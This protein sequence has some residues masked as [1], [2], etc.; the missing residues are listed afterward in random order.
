MVW[1]KG[2][3]A[4]TDERL[5]TV[6]RKLSL[7]WSDK[8][9]KGLEFFRQRQTNYHCDKCD[10]VYASLLSFKQHLG[11]HNKDRKYDTSLE[12]Y[13]NYGMSKKQHTSNS[14]KRMSQK[15]KELIASRYDEFCEYLL[16]GR[17]I[18]KQS[19][20][21]YDSVSFESK[22]ELQIAKWL[23]K[24]NII[25]RVL[26]GEN[27]Q[28]RIGNKFFDFKLNN[29][30]IE[31]HPTQFF[32]YHG[33]KFGFDYFVARRQ[34]LDENNYNNCELFVFDNLHDCSKFIKYELKEALVH[35]EI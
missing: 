33:A 28:F 25:A 2:L 18:S 7:S 6:G 1:N 9:Q 22:A 24:Y 8:R 32:K 13:S 27:Y 19:P 5:K 15:S 31:Y 26:K 29:I 17:L 34:I 10:K 20:Y 14:K 21:F 11:I 12:K 3:S 30:F 4:Q 23:L 35:D 16:K